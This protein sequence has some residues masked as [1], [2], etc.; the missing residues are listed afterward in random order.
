MTNTQRPGR[1]NRLIEAIQGFL[2]GG[3]FP[4][5][6]IALLVCWEVFLI[7]VLLFP[8]SPSAF[9]S[10]AEDFRIW[11]FGYDP[12]TGRT[13][14]A[15]VMAMLL[16][17]VMMGSFIA[18]FWWGPLREMLRSPKRAVV[19]VGVA[20]LIVAGSTL[21][22]AY[23]TSIPP[24]GDMPF[25]AEVIR[26]AFGSPDL[27]LVNQEGSPVDLESLRRGQ[28]HDRVAVGEQHLTVGHPDRVVAQ[29]FRQRIKADL[30]DVGHDAKA[31]LHGISPRCRC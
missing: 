4:M 5:F 10:F 14:W 30:V 6:T 12:A 3:G 16:P 19:H 20:G 28:S 7:G 2:S 27:S 31:E 13:E 15:Y 18:L 29:I 9:G 26:T 24:T 21:G 1:F 22:F 8:P 23:S 11:C 17:Q 25:P